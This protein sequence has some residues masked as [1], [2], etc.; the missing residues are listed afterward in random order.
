[1]NGVVGTQSKAVVLT[2]C[3]VNGIA[4][5]GLSVCG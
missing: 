1:M 3:V 4:D 2:A 5:M